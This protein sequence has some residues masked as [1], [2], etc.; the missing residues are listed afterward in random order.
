MIA[1]N[2]YFTLPTTAPRRPG[3]GRRLHRYLAHLPAVFY[4]AG[5]PADVDRS[6]DDPST[7]WRCT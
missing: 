5:T 6:A 4:A 2:V 3:L 7:T 1:H